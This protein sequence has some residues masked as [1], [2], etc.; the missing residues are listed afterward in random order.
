MT[1]RGDCHV[2]VVGLGDKIPKADVLVCLLDALYLIGRDPAQPQKGSSVGVGSELWGQ[3]GEGA[4]QDVG[5]DNVVGVLLSVW[6]LTFLRLVDQLRVESV[7]DAVYHGVMGAGFDGERLD[8][9]P[10]GRPGNVEDERRDGQDP[11]PG[12]N[13]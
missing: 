11:A 4:L 1:H 3:L 9:C 2:T 7:S 6:G 13:V 5:H 12:T 8:V 10:D